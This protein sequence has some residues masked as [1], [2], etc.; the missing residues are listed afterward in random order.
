MSSYFNSM[1]AFPCRDVD[2]QGRD[3]SPFSERL[4][5]TSVTRSSSVTRSLNAF[6]SASI[7]LKVSVRCIKV[8]SLL[9]EAAI[10]VAI[11]V[12]GCGCTLGGGDPSCLHLPY[13][14]RRRSIP[15]SVAICVPVSGHATACGQDGRHAGDAGGNASFCT[16]PVR[17]ANIKR[18][19]RARSWTQPSPLH[20]V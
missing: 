9:E 8:C 17:S 11:C 4:L 13:A 3:P 10:S 14:W 20:G 7:L 18:A 12:P 15:C 1:S 2:L 19:Q 6:K 16:W 5:S